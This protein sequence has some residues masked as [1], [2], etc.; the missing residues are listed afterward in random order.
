MLS[1]WDIYAPVRA[2]SE[3]LEYGQLRSGSYLALKYMHFKLDWN[4]NLDTFT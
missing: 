3:N 2:F 1:E 4:S